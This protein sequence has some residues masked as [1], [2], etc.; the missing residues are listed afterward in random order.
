MLIPQ[1][2]VRP[3]AHPMQGFHPL[4][5]SPPLV[6]HQLSDQPARVNFTKK[7]FRVKPP[8][9]PYPRNPNLNPNPTFPWNCNV[10]P[11]R[12]LKAVAAS[13]DQ[14]TETRL[15]V[16]RGLALTPIVTPTPAL[17]RLAP[18]PLLI[19]YPTSKT[20][21]PHPTHSV[22]QH[23]EQGTSTPTHSVP[24][25]QDQGTSTS[26]HSIPHTQDQ[27]TQPH[28]FSDPAVT[29]NPIVAPSTPIP[30]LTT[31][32]VPV[33]RKTQCSQGT[34]VQFTQ[35]NRIVTLHPV[36]TPLT[37]TIAPSA[38]SATDEQVTPQ[39]SLPTLVRIQVSIPPDSA[40]HSNTQATEVPNT[41][42]K[43]QTQPEYTQEARDK[44]TIGLPCTITKAC[45]RKNKVAHTPPA[46]YLE[47]FRPADPPSQ[48][49][50]PQIL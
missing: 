16:T 28:S 9:P 32:P 18:Q 43:P 31:T 24:Q 20:K 50:P 26:P 21:A 44:S 45:D 46:D 41:T 8:P 12:P 33:A 7:Q 15:R 11:G 37:P 17:K 42:V 14:A 30:D 19:P 49:T 38:A 34:Q 39:R 22:P 36:A 5:P 25:R 48:W 1:V 10:L 47:M 27:G 3:S 40:L 2:W 6:A 13:K 23:Q 35:P 4:V 29:V